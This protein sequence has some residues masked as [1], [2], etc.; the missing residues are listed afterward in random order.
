MRSRPRPL[1]CELHAHTTWS[2]GVLTLT[3]LVDLY[4]QSGFDVLAVTDHAIRADDPWP[5]RPVVREDDFPAYLAAVESEARRARVAYDLLVLP[6]LELTYDDADPARAA[7]AVA[8]GLRE[9]VDLGSG[10]EQALADARAAGAALIAAHPY[11]PSTA[12]GALRRTSR[13]AADRDE[14]A[15]LVDRFE[16]VNRRELFAWV[17]T[18]G[19]AA[20]ATGDFHVPQ[21][22]AGWKTLLPCA[23]DEE[24]VIAYLRSGLPAY[25]V[26]LAEPALLQVAA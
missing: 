19:L 16:L 9:H 22:L 14:L 25:L 7:H 24:A 10:L 20:V 3:E 17:A 5:D 12:A 18:A 23:P 2:D 4:G 26:D 21:H 13:W 1:L 11:E 8:V 15:A 6:G